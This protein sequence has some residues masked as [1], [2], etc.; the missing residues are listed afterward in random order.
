MNWTHF[1]ASYAHH[2]PMI[3]QKASL[4]NVSKLEIG[5][6]GCQMSACGTNRIN[7][8]GPAKEKRHCRRGSSNQISQPDKSRALR[9]PPNSLSRQGMVSVPTFR[10]SVMAARPRLA[11]LCLD[12]GRTAAGTFVNFGTS[13]WRLIGLKV[14]GALLVA[15]C[16]VEMRSST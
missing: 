8:A 4:L 12:L 3:R 10:R 11:V 15:V 5:T 14:S 2:R 6:S 7:Q 1:A 16:D 13:G 9:R